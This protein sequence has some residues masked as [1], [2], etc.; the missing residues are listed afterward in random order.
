LQLNNPYRPRTPWDNLSGYIRGAI[1][2]S[3]EGV[4]AD[5]WGA[6]LAI[7]SIDDFRSLASEERVIADWL[8]NDYVKEAAKWCAFSGVTSGVG[9]VLTAIT[10]G[11]ADFI[12]VAGR[13]YRLCVRL[14]IL[15]G[16]DPRDPVDRVQIEEVYLS[17]LGFD[18]TEKFILGQ[19]L[20]RSTTKPGSLSASISYTKLIIAVGRKLWARRLVSRVTGRFLPLFGATVGAG[21]NYYFARRAGRKMRE[22]FQRICLD[23]GRL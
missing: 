20:G 9:G 2:V 22:N 15:N 21:A 1:E 3:P 6:G 4:M 5:A 11:A 23:T 12:H 16:L 13:L 19:F 14:A 18:P 8:A 10:L 17:S 7:S